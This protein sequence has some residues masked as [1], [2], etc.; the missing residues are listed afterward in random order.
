MRLVAA[1]ALLSLSL[2]LGEAR[3]VDKYSAAYGTAPGG[4]VA[5]LPQGRPNPPEGPYA[6]N[7]D[8]TVMYTGNTSWP[9]PPRGA[10][11]QSWQ[12]WLWLSKNDM[13][14]SDSRDYYPHLSAGR[15]GIL[16]QPAGAGAACNAS[17]TMY[18]G[19]ASIAHVLSAGAGASVSSTTRVLENNAVV[20]TLVC[21]SP[22]GGPCALT[23]LLSD[24]DGNHYGVEQDAGAP[25]DG[26]LVWWRKENLH[27]ALNPAHLG[28]CDPL[29]PLQSTERAFTVGAQGALAMANGSCLWSDEAA[30]PGVVTVGACAA[31]QGAWTWSAGPAGRGD[32][33][34]TASA[35]CLTSAPGGVALGPCGAAPWAQLPAGDGNASHVYLNATSGAQG[36]CLVAVPDN[37]NNTLGVALGVAD[38]SGSLVKGVA[39]PVSPTDPS[40]GITLTLSLASGAPYSLIVGLQTLRDQGCAGIRPQ[41]ETCAS[42]PQA[43]AAALVQALAGTAALA[44]AAAASDAFWA[45]YWAASAVDITTGAAP[46]ASAQ[47]AVIERWYYMHQYLLACTTR[48]GKVTPALDGFVCIEPVPW[49]DQFSACF[50]CARACQIFGHLPPACTHTQLSAHPHTHAPRTHTQLWITTWRPRSGAR[51]PPT[52]CPS[53]TPSWPPPPTPAPWPLRAC[54]R[55]TPARG[56]RMRTGTA[57]WATPWRGQC[58]TPTTAP[59]SPPRALRALNGPARE[60]P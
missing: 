32:I 35:K 58:A 47:L 41:W 5:A 20:T 7:G 57:P 49:G 36:G 28:P 45:G 33:V 23:L 30:A 14:G 22:G 1:A 51:G 18:P 42:T 34:H 40:A 29:V 13:W 10:L 55:R 50:A 52:A 24:T 15:V 25:A 26:S 48:D 21:T 44:A 54:A 8:V 19:N 11:T 59:T 53:S 12:Q 6:G 3:S 27:G 56:A 4:D 39:A 46:N 60:C 9:P 17:V 38:S 31:P 43:A 16:A 2:P 37:N